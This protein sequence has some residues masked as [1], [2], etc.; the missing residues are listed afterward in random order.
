MSKT[1]WPCK[2]NQLSGMSRRWLEA[3]DAA[4]RV[5]HNDISLVKGY[6]TARTEAEKRSA[7]PVFISKNLSRTRIISSSRFSRQTRT[8]HSSGRARLFDSSRPKSK[9]RRR[10]VLLRSLMP[11]SKN[12]ASEWARRGKKSRR[13]AY[14]NP[15]PIESS[16][17][18]KSILFP[19]G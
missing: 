11:L 19:G 17:T 4:M 5:A 9:S 3:G 7:I 12:S 2:E 15:E 6:H 16:W 8:H 10:K 13:S 18:I 1:R 14:T